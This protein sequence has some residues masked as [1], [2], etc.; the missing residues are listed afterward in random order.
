[1][2]NNAQGLRIGGE[3]D[4]LARAAVDP[5]VLSVGDRNVIEERVDIRLGR[6]VLASES[7][8]ILSATET[9]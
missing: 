6:F 4:K 2:K 8:P 7:A 5:G 9:K 1:M 3:D